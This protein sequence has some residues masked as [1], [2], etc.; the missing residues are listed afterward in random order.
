MS[1]MPNKFSGFLV[2]LRDVKT[3]TNS[4]LDK[5][6]IIMLFENLLNADLDSAKELSKKIFPTTQAQYT[7]GI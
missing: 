4:L 3:E 1:D 5:G 6:K 7:K 2:D